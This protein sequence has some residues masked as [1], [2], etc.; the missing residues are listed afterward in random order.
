VRPGGG[1]L[2]P[3][4]AALVARYPDRF[5]IGTDTWVPSQWTRLPSLMA[6]VRVWLRQLPADLAQAIAFDNAQRLLN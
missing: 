1:R 6:D 4:W 5:M 2:D 3:E